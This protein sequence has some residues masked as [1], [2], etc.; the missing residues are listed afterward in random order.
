METLKKPDAS[1][2]ATSGLS[3]STENDNNTPRAGTIT[4]AE[5][6]SELDSGECGL[7]GERERI[8]KGEY[9]AAY[10]HYETAAVFS[11]GIKG[12][13]EIRRGGK[14][15]LWFNIDPYKNSALIDARDNIK[16]FVSYNAASITRPF[17]KNGKFKM[18]RGKRFVQDYEKFFGSVKRRDRISPNKYK[19]KLLKVHVDD[20]TRDSGQHK[21]PEDQFYSVIDELVSIETG[22]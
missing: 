8:P 20:V 12:E 21:Y 22:I 14:V 18:T 16:L 2:V 6:I 19:G 11:C 5:T 9:Q 13:K 15:Y 10:S 3:K 7:I 4:H 1:L 17:G